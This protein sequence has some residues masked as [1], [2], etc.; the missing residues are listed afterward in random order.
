MS[1]SDELRRFA[2]FEQLG[3]LELQALS[4]VLIRRTLPVGALLFQKDDPGDTLLLI[5]VGQVRI[6]MRDA[7]GNEITF[8]SYSAGQMIGEFSLLDRRPRS[9][10][11]IVTAPLQLFVLPR[12]AF[13]G[14]LQ[15]RPLVG[16][17]LMRSLAERI[18]YTTSY[19]ERL[20]DALELLSNSEYEAA[21]RELTISADDDEMQQLISAFLT[22]A[23]RAQAGDPQAGVPQAGDAQ[24]RVTPEQH[25]NKP[26]S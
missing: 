25:K 13:L 12:E 18:R 22:L 16:V 4:A 1:I 2:L 17:Q 6:F 26:L 21:I 3:A 24:T 5:R 10:S 7:D 9:A 14:L 8:R 15:Q 19:L 23:R 11:A 20:Y